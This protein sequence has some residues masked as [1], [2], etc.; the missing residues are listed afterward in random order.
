[1]KLQERIRRLSELGEYMAGPSKGWQQVKQKAYD[2]NHWFI[3]EFT[4]AAV[5]NIIRQFLQ[6]NI[7]EKWSLSYRLPELNDQPVTVGIVMAGNIPLVGFHD[8]LSVLISGNK[9]MIKPSGKDQAL[10]RHLGEQLLHADARFSSII[11]FAENLKGCQAYI[12]TGSN[13]SSRYFDYYFGK[14]PHLIRKNKTSVAILTGKE[15]PAELGNLAVDVYRYFGLGCRNVTKI[16]VPAG[17]DFLPLLEAFKKYNYLADHHHYRSNYD[18]RMTLLI[19]NKQDYMTNGSLILAENSHLFSPVSV[20]HYEFYR[21][22]NSMRRGLQNSPELQCIVG[23][24]FIPFGKSQEPAVNEYADG[25]DTMQFLSTLPVLV[26][27]N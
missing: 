23:K 1:M 16:Y 27:Q 12:A 4:Q 19:L 8:L 11:S 22:E 5:E 14:Y 9:A 10:I 18:Y 17:Y 6:I 2:E 20:L 21:D 25:A 24:G 15:T 3:P 13:T 7:L 26:H